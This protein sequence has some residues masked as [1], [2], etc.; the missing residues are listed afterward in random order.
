M[1]NSVTSESSEIFYNKNSLMG[2]GNNLVG[3]QIRGKG[4]IIINVK[5]SQNQYLFLIIFFDFC[6]NF[7][8]YMEFV[9]EWGVDNK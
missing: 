6:R 5:L 1:E 3:Q 2:N 9:G 4:I 8:N 7:S